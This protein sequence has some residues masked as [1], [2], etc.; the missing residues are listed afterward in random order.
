MR[1][2]NKSLIMLLLMILFFP[3]SCKVPAEEPPKELFENLIQSYLES[4]YIS[5]K[6]ESPLDD[7]M[8]LFIFDVNNAISVNRF[9]QLNL[10]ATLGQTQYYCY[11]ISNSNVWYVLKRAY[12]YDEPYSLDKAEIFDYYFKYEDAIVY[13]YNGETGKYDIQ[14]DTNEYQALVDYRS[15]VS[16]IDEIEKAD[17]RSQEP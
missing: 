4:E 12:F 14:A 5:K 1:M 11:K 13:A 6:I 10:F 9:Y 2:V 8:E 7:G 3:I 17:T 15:L 16:V